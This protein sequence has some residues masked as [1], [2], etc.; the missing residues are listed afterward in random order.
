[1]KL[2]LADD[3]FTHLYYMP[4]KEEKRFAKLVVLFYFSCKNNG[5][6][7]RYLLLELQ[8]EGFTAVVQRLQLFL[9][10]L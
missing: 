5:S 9:S 6:D 2:V 3:H 10:M 4:S 7:F 8:Q 1:M